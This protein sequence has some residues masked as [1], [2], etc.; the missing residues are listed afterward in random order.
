MRR[1]VALGVCAGAVVLGAVLRVHFLH[2][3]LITDEGGYA[4]I[5][6]LW[7]EGYRLY[8]DVAWVVRHD[9]GPVSQ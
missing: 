7:S 1:G 4:A 2:V 5:S 8:G 3:P 6:R 9:S